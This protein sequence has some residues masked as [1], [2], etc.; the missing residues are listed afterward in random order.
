MKHSV[1][2]I[3]FRLFAA[4]AASTLARPLLSTTVEAVRAEEPLILKGDQTGSTIKIAHDYLPVTWNVATSIYANGSP[5]FALPND[6]RVKAEGDGW[7]AVARIHKPTVYEWTGSF[8]D[9]RWETP[10]NWRPKGVPGRLDTIRLGSDA[11]IDLGRDRMVSNIVFSAKVILA[12]GAVHAQNTIGRGVKAKLGVRAGS[13]LGQIKE[14]DGAV[15]QPLRGMAGY[16]G[17]LET[18]ADGVARVAL[19]RPSASYTWTG[20]AHDCKWTTLKNWLVKGRLPVEPPC[21]QDQAIFPL[22]KGGMT[23]VKLP[24]GQTVVSNLVL[25]AR[26]HWEGSGEIDVLGSGGGS[27]LDVCDLSG[28]E[29]FAVS[30]SGVTV[31]MRGA[32]DVPIVAGSGVT[33]ALSRHG[34]KPYRSV[35]LESGA[36]LIPYDWPVKIDDFVLKGDNAI[37]FAPPRHFNKW[38]PIWVVHAKHLQGEAVLTTDDRAHWRQNVE[39]WNDGSSMM[40]INWKD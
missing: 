24:S 26:V 6:Y 17:V 3:A 1:Q 20:A 35:T 14:M 34:Q 38:R 22:P 16:K 5:Q 32:T 18:D 29:K 10:G 33:L 9:G 11:T 40:T 31:G 4:I 28:T 27:S 36:S 7:W 8:G 13:C 19:T 2:R 23:R 39:K 21:E 15:V 12:K 25:K 37:C 30:G